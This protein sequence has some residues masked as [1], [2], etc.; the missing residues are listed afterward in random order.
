MKNLIFLMLL[1]FSSNLFAQKNLGIQAEYNCLINGN[2]KR[3]VLESHQ[4]KSFFHYATNVD[5]SSVTE[6]EDDYG[7]VNLKI[8]LKTDDSTKAAYFTDRVSRM[9]TYRESIY[10]KG[11][12]EPFVVREPI[13]GIEW[14]IS[15]ET[16]TV[17]KYTCQ[18]AE[19][20]FRGR[21]YTAWF[22]HDIPVQA[23]PWKLH[24]LPG[25]ILEAYDKD[26]EI[27]FALASLQIPY[28]PSATLAPP[29]GKAPIGFTEF[30][31]IRE[32]ASQNFGKYIQ[33][34]LP[35][36]VTFHVDKVENNWLERSF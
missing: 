10:S 19:G 21:I 36:G 5:K 31:E 25:L 26:R 32:D 33:A 22:T 3:G 27:Y 13:P 6:S 15:K 35:R 12:L 4:N 7:K 29:T 1:A 18:K 30:M 17:G 34:K 8:S 24:G 16:K 20:S 2:K 11:K 9:M 28:V 23:G 14:R